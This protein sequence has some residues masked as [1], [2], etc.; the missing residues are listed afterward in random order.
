MVDINL[1]KDDDE[2]KEFNASRQGGED[3]KEDISGDINFEDDLTEPVL[4]DEDLLGDVD[5]IPDMNRDDA[6][7]DTDEDYAYVASRGRK[8]PLW[9]WAFLGLICIGAAVYL[10]IIQPRMKKEM[11][12]V[13]E[14]E[15]T[16][17]ITGTEPDSVRAAQ[18]PAEEISETPSV[19][20]PA[21]F[22]TQTIIPSA[23][24]ASAS[25]AVVEDLA[26]SGQFATLLLNGDQV[27]V[28]Y[29]SKTPDVVK[30]MGH[31]I[32]TLLGLSDYTA[33]PEDRHRTAG[34]ITYWGV[35]SGRLPAGSSQITPGGSNRF[36]DVQSFVDEV[37]SQLRQKRLIVKGSQK[38]INA[39]AVTSKQSC[40]RIEIEGT[41]EDAL[42]YLTSLQQF[43]GNFGVAKLL[44]APVSYADFS[45]S[46][47]K[48]VLDFLIQ[49]G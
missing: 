25:K 11:L 47:I 46:R 24:V 29:I 21:G 42:A 22:E 15:R 14:P 12:V 20:I 10:F 48:M 16:P 18:A 4:D 49:F 7:F 23:I 8:A 45:A 13:R 30:I 26:R 6:S 43:T 35:I 39:E 41:R 9:L 1:L 37:K 33:S 34:E 5:A 44:M 2:E 38:L 40:V 17:L 28:E 3:F 31:R 36:T 27:F 32:Q 19:Q